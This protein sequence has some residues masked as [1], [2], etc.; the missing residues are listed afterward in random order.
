VVKNGRYGPYVTH[1][2][3]N[4]TLPRDKTPDTIT[5]DEASALIDARAES[6]AARRPRKTA[7]AAPRTPKADGVSAPKKAARKKTAKAKAAE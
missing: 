2:G 3:I 5:L 7:R 1:E 4:A 6:G